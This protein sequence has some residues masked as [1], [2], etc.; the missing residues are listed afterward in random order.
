MKRLSSFH[1]LLIFSGIIITWITACDPV[2]K[3]AKA[4]NEEIARYF[5]NNPSLDFVQYNSG[6]YY[7]EV[8][9]GSGPQVKTHDSAFIKHTIKFLHG[10][11][12][13]TNIGKD[14]TLKEPVNEGWLLTGFDEGLSYMH[15]GGKSILLL[16]S[17]LAYGPGGSQEVPG[18]TPIL[19]ELN[20]VK[21]KPYPFT[22]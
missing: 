19:I 11:I 15:E 9:A 20:L 14:D 3:R 1:Y 7:C 13:Y 2:D 21:V 22:R 8:E 16:P 5:A 12:I 4:E 10:T 6:L 17:Y 18:Y